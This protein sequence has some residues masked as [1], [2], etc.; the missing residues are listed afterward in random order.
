MKIKAFFCIAH[1]AQMT[2]NHNFTTAKTKP[3]C[4]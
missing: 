1:I 2:I 3:N 4:I